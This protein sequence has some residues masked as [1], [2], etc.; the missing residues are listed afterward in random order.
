MVARVGGVGRGWGRARPHAQGLSVRHRRGGR[1]G[2]HRRGWRVGAAAVWVRRAY[3]CSGL[4][5]EFPA[6]TDRLVERERIQAD[7]GCELQSACELVQSVAL[8]KVAVRKLGPRRVLRILDELDAL[9]AGGR[10]R[11][12][13]GGEKSKGGA[14]GRGWPLASGRSGARRDLEEDCAQLGLNVM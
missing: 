7:G 8:H 4:V 5:G 14:R 9:S 1:A 10:T 13:A 2:E 6:Q 11:R 12:S 3:G